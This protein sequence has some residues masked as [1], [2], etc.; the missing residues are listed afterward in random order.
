MRALLCGLVLLLSG[1]VLPGDIRDMKVSQAAY[2]TKLDSQV[3]EWQAGVI[4][5]DQFEEAV[6][7][8]TDDYNAQLEAKAIEIERR[9]QDAIDAIESG[10]TLAETGGIG[11][12]IT[13]AGGIGLNMLRNRK[14]RLPPAMAAR[15]ADP[16]T[17][18]R[19]P[20]A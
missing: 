19:P 20:D 3:R 8:I 7:E 14:Y 18:P 15:M 17:V 4:S 2:R 12:L 9:T 16:N 10:L 11:G 5:E 6:E 13:L 1:C